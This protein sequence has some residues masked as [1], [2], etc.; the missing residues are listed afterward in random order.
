MIL[1]ICSDLWLVM[2]LVYYMIDFFMKK[3]CGNNEY[4]FC[5]KQFLDQLVQ[6]DVDWFCL[7]EFGMKF[8]FDLYEV[9]F[10]MFKIFVVFFILDKCLIKVFG[11]YGLIC[12][13]QKMVIKNVIDSSDKVSIFDIEK[14]RVICEKGVKF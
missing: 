8:Y 14:F 9:E 3:L 7:Y 10:M 5:M 13:L 2:G 6:I 4:R 11:G 12:I 1:N